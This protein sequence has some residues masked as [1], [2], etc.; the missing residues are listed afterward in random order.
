MIN[1]GRNK[2]HAIILYTILP[3]FT[4]SGVGLDL[5]TGKNKLAFNTSV[6]VTVLKSYIYF[7]FIIFSNKL[8]ILHAYFKRL[9]GG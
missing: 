8:I 9:V 1:Y 4:I 7:N 2:L 3:S 5:N 6:K